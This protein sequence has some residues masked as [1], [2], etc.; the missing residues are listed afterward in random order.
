MQGNSSPSGNMFT[1]T[2][3]LAV[4][5]DPSSGGR[6]HISVNDRI[7]KSGTAI[8]VKFFM[9]VGAIAQAFDAD[10]SNVVFGM[11]VDW[12]STSQNAR[13]QI[14][15]YMSPDVLSGFTATF[16]NTD[17]FAAGRPLESAFQS[18]WY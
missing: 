3:D 9:G 10:S 8:R 6:G 1:G 14:W 18:A 11:V 7:T 2:F 12:G 15:R 13:T 16:G 5:W 17:P 4:A